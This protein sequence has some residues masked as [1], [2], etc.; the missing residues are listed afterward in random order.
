MPACHLR[1]QCSTTAGVPTHPHGRR[2]RLHRLMRAALAHQQEEHGATGPGVGRLPALHQ[3]RVQGHHDQLPRHAGTQGTERT[4][5]ACRVLTR[6]SFVEAMNGG[7]VGTVDQWE[8]GPRGQLV[9]LFVMLA[10]TS[11]VHTR[12]TLMTRR[13][14]RCWTSRSTWPLAT[15]TR[16]SAASRP[17][18]TRRCGRTWRTCASATSAWTWRVS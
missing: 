5:G 6:L 3:Q 18:K 12:R 2:H 16:R 4:H 10:Q 13:V 15:W 1:T 8:R 11:H 17:S 9:S 14:A 7:M